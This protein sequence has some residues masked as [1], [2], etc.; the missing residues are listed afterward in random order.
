[1]LLITFTWINIFFKKKFM[2]KI[3]SILIIA[4]VLLVSCIND[5]NQVVVK[6]VV[7]SSTAGL[8]INYTPGTSNRLFEIIDSK[9]WEFEYEGSKGESYDVRVESLSEK[10]S[11]TV[12]VYYDNNLIASLQ[13]QGDYPYLYLRGFL[14]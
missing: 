6:Y 3:V 1:M 5:D 13:K 11:I 14:K 7:K 2:K 4:I 12:E 8:E 9:E 10:T